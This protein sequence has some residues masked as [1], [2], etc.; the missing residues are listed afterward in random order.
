[1]SLC[2][3]HVCDFH[4]TV[5]ASLRRRRAFFYREILLRFA[6]L[7]SQVFASETCLS[8]VTMAHSYNLPSLHLQQVEDSLYQI[9]HI[10]L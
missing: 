3:G 6:Q 7:D 1:M 5:N 9:S 10:P 4:V 2:D 8:P